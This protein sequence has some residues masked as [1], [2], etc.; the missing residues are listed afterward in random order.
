M[1]KDMYAAEGCGLAA[2]QVGEL[3]QLIVIDVDY[4]KGTKNPYVLINPRIVTADG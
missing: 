4:A 2:P 3:V 1:L